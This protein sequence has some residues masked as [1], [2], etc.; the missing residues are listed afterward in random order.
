MLMFLLHLTIMNLVSATIILMIKKK[1][2]LAMNYVIYG[3]AILLFIQLFYTIP[4]VFTDM[5][6]LFA[7]IINLVVFSYL[8]YIKKTKEI[9]KS[10]LESRII[11]FYV[12]SIGL[13]ILLLVVTALKLI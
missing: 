2:T 11:L 4:R 13:F 3:I 8:I 9:E 10:K 5:K 7:I 12:V 1:R 6:M